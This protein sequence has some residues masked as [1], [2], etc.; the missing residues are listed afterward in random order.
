MGAKRRTSQMLKYGGHVT[1]EPGL[2]AAMSLAGDNGLVVGAGTHL[3]THTA[4]LCDECGRL[5]ARLVL[6]LAMV[7]N[8]RRL[9]G[10]RCRS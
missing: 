6:Q 3:D 2:R 4:A 7:R 8:M 10:V 5:V 1:P 9:A